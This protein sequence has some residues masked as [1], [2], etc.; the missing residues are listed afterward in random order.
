MTP[1]ARQP[2]KGH[3]PKS[4]ALAVVLDPKLPLLWWSGLQPQE[5]R[6]SRPSPHRNR[7]S[8]QHVIP[9]GFSPS[10]RARGISSS[11]RQAAKAQKHERKPA[12]SC[13]RWDAKLGDSIVS[14]FFFREARR[15]NARVTVL[16]VVELA[17]AHTQDFG[18]DQV[19]ITN[20]NP[21]VLELRRLAQQLG[22]V[23]VVV[24][25][26]GRIQ[27]A[28]ILFCDCCVRPAC[29]HSMTVYAAS[30][31]SSVKQLLVSTWPSATDVYS[32]TWVQV[33][34]IGSTSSPFL[35]RCRTPPSP[36]K[37]YST[38][39]PAAQTNAWPSTDP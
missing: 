37:S 11:G 18:V 6:L 25:L 35:T 34:S 39:T 1:P 14:S 29:T 21:G 24:H 13:P 33:W 19:V 28:E 30:I 12:H 8:E 16:T 17:Q 5:A 32:W 2:A 36:R 31:A 3:A 7:A 9:T 20:A 10:S 26:V 22:Q 27:P 15:L 38:P 23:D 4:P